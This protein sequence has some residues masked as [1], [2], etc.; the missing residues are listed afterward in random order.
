MLLIN[1]D[2][3]QEPRG[4]AVPAVKAARVQFDSDIAVKMKGKRTN[5]SQTGNCRSEPSL[6]E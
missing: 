2:P 6:D 3:D 1:K 4:P 5:G